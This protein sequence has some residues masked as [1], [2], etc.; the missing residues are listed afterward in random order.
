MSLRGVYD[1]AISISYSNIGKYVNSLSRLP[2]LSARNDQKKIVI[3]DYIVTNKT[4]SLRGAFSD[5]AVSVR[6]SGIEKSTEIATLMSQTLTMYTRND[7]I[8]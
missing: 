1:V 2:R 5:V 3:P 6:Y 8:N 7:V 4:T